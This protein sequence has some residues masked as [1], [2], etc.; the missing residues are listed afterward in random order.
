[1]AHDAHLSGISLELQQVIDR[2]RD[3][4]FA[5]LKTLKDF[6][7]RI[8]AFESSTNPPTAAVA[9]LAAKVRQT[10]AAVSARLAELRETEQPFQQRVAQAQKLHDNLHRLSAALQE[11]LDAVRPALRDVAAIKQN[12]TAAA[13]AAVS[14]AQARLTDIESPVIAEIDRLHATEQQVADRLRQLQQEVDDHLASLLDRAEHRLDAALTDAT[15][16]SH[17]AL[18]H[19]ERR[20]RENVDAKVEGRLDQLRGV[21]DEQQ[22]DL[23]RHLLD[24]RRQLMDLLDARD[25][26]VA[27]ALAQ[28][29]RLVGEQVQAMV[30]Q[31]L[32][33]AQAAFD[34]AVSNARQ[35]AHQQ[36]AD[37][38]DSTAA[39]LDVIRSRIARQLADL[40]RQATAAT[41]PTP[42][43]AVPAPQ[44]HVASHA[45][46]AGPS[47][48]IASRIGAVQPRPQSAA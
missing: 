14:A 20:L 7:Q 9:Q 38:R 11:Q 39:M 33:Q 44:L 8:A 4:R 22:R 17:Q 37:L 24:D 15:Q 36:V 48:E 5:L 30:G 18:S 21:L 26:Q 45:D 31:A 6:E 10:D 42:P 12:L 1:M 41:S 2:A 43:P 19:F 25:R 23:N 3:E 28:Q 40:S 46:L 47:H 16:R 27:D 35:H 34:S 29:Q 13:D 32:S